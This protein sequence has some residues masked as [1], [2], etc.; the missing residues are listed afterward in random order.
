MKKNVLI[1]FSMFVVTFCFAQNSQKISEI[2]ETEEISKGQASYFV[3]V[4]N[5][6]GE[7]D[8]SENESF[9]FL[10]EKFFFDESENSDEKISL[11]KACFL[12][13]KSANMKGGIFYS[14]FKS[15]RYAFREFK[16]LGIL[17]QNV[18]PNQTVSGT[19]F[20]ALLN[21]FE[22]NAKKGD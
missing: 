9:D 3:C 15:P 1:L 12:I 16:S 13:G 7:E 6:F 22:K 17:P 5:S 20:I 4:Y 19:E 21:G 18:E 11:S 14:I 8:L 10:C 2:L